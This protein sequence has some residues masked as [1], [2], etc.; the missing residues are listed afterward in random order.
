MFREYIMKYDRHPLFLPLLIA[1]ILIIV[2]GIFLQIMGF[3]IEDGEGFEIIGFRFLIG[4]FIS[5]IF[6][7]FAQ[8]YIEIKRSVLFILIKL[9]MYNKSK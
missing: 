7:Y 3:S 4:G 5:I 8:Y 6:A 1:G 2:F 9:K